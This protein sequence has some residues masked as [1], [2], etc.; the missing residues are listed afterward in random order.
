M[1]KRWMLGGFLIVAV[2]FEPGCAT[3]RSD[4]VPLGKSGLSE[5]LLKEE[6]EIRQET[7][8]THNYFLEKRA[9]YEDEHLES[10]LA[11][12]TQSLVGDLKRDQNTTLQFK[13]LRDPTINASAMLTGHIYF[14]S[15]ILAKL[16]NEDQLAFV[17][18]HEISHVHHR[19][20]LYYVQNLKRKTVTFKVLDLILTPGAAFVGA[21]GLSGMALSLVYGASV[22]GYG[23]EEESAAD[24]FALETLLKTG[25]DPCK[26]TGF[27]DVLLLEKEKYKQGFEIYFLSSHPSN[28]HRKKAAQKWIDEHKADIEKNAPLFKANNAFSPH[29]YEVLLENAKLNLDLGRYFHA[30]ENIEQLRKENRNDPSVDFLEGE[31]YRMMAERPEKVQEELSPKTWRAIKGSEKEKRKKEWREKSRAAFEKAISR[32]AAY[33]P[34]YKSLGV[35]YLA[36][37]EYGKA[38]DHFLKY[39]ELQPDAKDRRSVVRY[40]SDIEEAVRGG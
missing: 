15:G 17:M 35:F 30:L 11:T 3:D 40:L 32:D 10:Y 24:L 28:T 14:H 9:F 39:L 21:H 38:K 5:K 2:F 6:S 16:K 20:V 22:Q 13:I 29:A 25:Y 8:A 4:I 19:D 23:R 27:F 26:V 1:L 33:A 18:A 37:K 12:L 36:E 7:L 31:V 34:T